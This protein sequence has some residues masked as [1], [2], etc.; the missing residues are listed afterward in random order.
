LASVTGSRPDVPDEPIEMA[1][2]PKK[3]EKKAAPFERL[4]LIF[5]PAKTALE[6][7]NTAQTE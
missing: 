6:T 2:N 3:K 1:V 7:L 5:L 4:I